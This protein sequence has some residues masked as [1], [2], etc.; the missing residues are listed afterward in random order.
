M[1]SMARKINSFKA[2]ATSKEKPFL[3]LPTHTLI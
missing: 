1:F 3:V 2:T